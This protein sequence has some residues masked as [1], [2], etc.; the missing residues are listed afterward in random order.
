MD[1]GRQL[2]QRYRKILLINKLKKGILCKHNQT[3]CNRYHLDGDFVHEN[4]EEC[5]FC[6]EKSPKILFLYS[7]V[8]EDYVF[9]CRKIIND[10]LLV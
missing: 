4:N 3:F 10:F 2:V 7:K 8:I 1:I 9:L 6:L 5:Y